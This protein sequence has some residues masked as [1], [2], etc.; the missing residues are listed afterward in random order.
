MKNDMLVGFGGLLLASY[1]EAKQTGD[2]SALANSE[3][4]PGC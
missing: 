4:L 3:N 2:A 1:A